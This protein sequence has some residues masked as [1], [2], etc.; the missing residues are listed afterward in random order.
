MRHLLLGAI[1]AAI[2]WASTLAIVK[3]AS[4]VLSGVMWLLTAG[5]GAAA[6]SAWTFAAALWATGIPEIVLAI[7]AL[8]AGVVLVYRNFDKLNSILPGL[9]DGLLMMLGPIGW[10]AEL[11]KN[12]DNLPG[13]FTRM[14]E[15][16]RTVYNWL[17]G[18]L[19]PVFDK[20]RQ[21]FAWSGKWISKIPGLGFLNPDVTAGTGT[22]EINK[23]IK[24]AEETDRAAAPVVQNIIADNG[25][26]S[27]FSDVIAARRRND[28]DIPAGGVRSSSKVNHWGGVN[29]FAPNGMGPGQLEEWAL[30]QG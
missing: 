2:A 7:A 1:P 23:V 20:V 8:V 15:G 5:I 6:A 14:G 9:G 19:V 17:A 10:I 26:D 11:I 24:T 27:A 21:F 30:L 25:T 13:I 12:W 29:I 3:G 22:Q 4:L 28:S 18:K 16:I